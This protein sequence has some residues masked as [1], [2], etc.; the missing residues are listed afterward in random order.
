ML[1]SNDTSLSEYWNEYRNGQGST[2]SRPVTALTVSYEFQYSDNDV[3]FCLLNIMSNHTHINT[4]IN[5]LLGKQ[6]T[7][8]LNKF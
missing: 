3:L 2:S 7:L 6:V 8:G 5:S 4:L 1:L